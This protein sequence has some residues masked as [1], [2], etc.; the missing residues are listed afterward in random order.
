M[1]IHNEHEE[2]HSARVHLDDLVAEFADAPLAEEID[3]ELLAIG[4]LLKA[5]NLAYGN[6]AIEPLR[7]FSSASP[8][9]QI[10]VRIDDK[11]SRISRGSASGEDVVLDLIGYLVLL[12]IAEKQGDAL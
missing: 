7:I 11:L 1:R 9:E 8:V 12:R 4:Y 2:F 5:K 10:R 3:S 6:S